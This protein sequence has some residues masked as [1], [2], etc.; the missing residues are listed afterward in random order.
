MWASLYINYFYISNDVYDRH[1][2][3]GDDV[4]DG[5]ALTGPLSLP[6]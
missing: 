3:I 5:K 1:V 2:Y 4:Y 6:R